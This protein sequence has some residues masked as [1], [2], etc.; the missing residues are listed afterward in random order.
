MK[1]LT[2]QR[3][4]RLVA[5]K[6]LPPATGRRNY[7]WEC[8]CDCGNIHVVAGGSL[9]SG[10]TKSCGCT[11]G[12]RF[13]L[14]DL[15]GQRFGNLVV[16]KRSTNNKSGKPRWLCECDCGKQTVVDAASLRR[17][18]TRSCGC[19]RREL[20]HEKGKGVAAYLAQNELKDGTNLGLLTSK[21][22]ESNKSGRKGVW[23]NERKGIYEA[24]IS[25]QKKR[26][27]LGSF[28]KLEDAIKAREQA[29]EELFEPMLNRYGRSLCDD[30]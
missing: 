20:N 23:F 18:V 24:Y 6:A 19:F 3:F 26:T 27:Y 21:M 15:T 12:K 28:R 5:V 29:E 4:G 30:V 22:Y 16:L 10:R 14:D 2:G 8:R 7:R 17:G 13:K 9:T 11:I 25:I 1:D